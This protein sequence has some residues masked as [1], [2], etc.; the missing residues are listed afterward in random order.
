MDESTPGRT[1][2]A[3]DSCV[4]GR[5]RGREITLNSD[6]GTPKGRRGR[7]S[8]DSKPRRGEPARLRDVAGDAGQGVDDVAREQRKRADALARD[9]GEDD[10]VLGHR[11]SVFTGEPVVE[12]LHSEQTSVVIGAAK[13]R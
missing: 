13:R 12:L 4:I 10:G 2:V 11:L 8:G 3:F 1:R 9:D 7:E 5:I 6:P